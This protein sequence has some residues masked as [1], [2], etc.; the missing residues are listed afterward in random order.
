MKVLTKRSWWAALVIL[1]ACL[2]LTL[3]SCKDSTST[4]PSDDPSPP[5]TDLIDQNMEN[6]LDN[7]DDTTAQVEQVDIKEIEAQ[8]QKLLADQE[9]TLKAQQEAAQ[10]VTDQAV[11]EAQ[12]VQQENPGQNTIP[13][14]I[15]LPRRMFVGTPTNIR[16]D[17]LEK[18]LGT[19]RPLLQVPEGTINL[20]FEKSVTSS[21]SNPIIGDLEQIT[22][23][24]KEGIDGNWVELMFGQQW[25]QIDL[26]A[27]AEIYAVVFW[28]YHSQPWVFRDVVVQVSGDPD[29]VNTTTLFN[30]DHDNS[31]GL[32][33]G[34][35]M[36]Y[37]ETSEG[38]LV[39]G[40]GVKARYVRLYS[41][42]NTENDS[43]QY[44]EVEVYGK[45]IK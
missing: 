35:D 11:Q 3:S 20:S 22:D 41:Y 13:L 5:T 7:T 9:A 2:S 25:V 32:G 27:S 14:E 12:Q 21:D 1:A 43:N 26:E 39:E 6:Q 18:P 24:D 45:L 30:N 29:F 28:H 33:A 10:K 31:L 19:D 17:R 4:E 16:I 42:G 37:V 38:K 40:N 36:H 44:T 23:G 34:E 15:L 8:M